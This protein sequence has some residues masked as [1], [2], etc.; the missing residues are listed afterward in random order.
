M[1]KGEARHE[2]LRRVRGAARGFGNR[3]PPSSAGHVPVTVTVCLS[4]GTVG[5]PQGTGHFWAYLNWALSLQA[6]GC[7]VV[8]LEDVG[9][10]L[11]SRPAAQAAQD[12]ATL[13]AR[14]ERWGL[15]SALALTDFRGC[16]VDAVL[17]RDGLDLEDAATASDLLLDFTYEAPRSVVSSFRRSALVDLDPGLLQIGMSRGDLRV[18]R[19]DAYFTI[20]ETVGTADARFPDGGVRWEYTPPPVFLGAWDPV[21]PKPGAAYTTVTNWWGEWILVDGETVDNEKRTAFMAL[22][23]LPARVPVTLELALTPD[24]H[25]METDARL[26]EQRG[27]KVRDAWEVCGTPEDYRD[28]IRRSRAELSAAKPSC[29]LLA[30]AWV[31]DRTI[32]YLASGKPAVVEHTG[33]SRILPD[34]E[35]LLRFRDIDEAAAAIAA[36]EA[37][38]EKHGR[39]A[40]ELA[41]AHFDGEHVVRGVL[42][43]A[44]P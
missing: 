12:V 18:E 9:G 10:L 1:P 33:C 35:G 28:Y 38:P 17:A 40:R 32:C 25:T 44:L 20:G 6:V 31:S 34:A 43:H 30:N 13:V 37:E 16:P 29:R 23:D 2:V 11:G 26:L 7:R 15:G 4:P 36:V 27:W 8:W 22:L 24:E 41:E 5:Y 42:E 14:L 39:W 19:H 3:L 21:D